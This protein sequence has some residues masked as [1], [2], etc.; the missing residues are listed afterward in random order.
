MNKEEPITDN[1]VLF[2]NDDVCILKPEVKKGILIFSNYRGNNS[3]ICTTGLKT[4][5]QLH[6][7][8]VEFSRSIYHPYIFFKAP[9]LKNII[10]YTSIDTE[11]ES[12]FGESEI[13]KPSRVWIRIDPERTYVYSSEIRAVYNPQLHFNSPKYLEAKENE[14]NN[15]R[16]L[17]TE[18]LEIIN[19]NSQIKASKNFKILYNL[20]SS[21]AIQF[22]YNIVPMY[23]YNSK[24]IN[25]NSEVLVRIPH[26]TPNYFVKCTEPVIT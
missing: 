23:P 10:D 11:I 3:T 17:M 9:Y 14:I 1:E 5:E 2:I 26:L 12:S 19:N 21:E 25:R 15:S 18:Y 22:P 6:I 20:Y 8:G 4:G 24:N 7:E 13:Y 16:K